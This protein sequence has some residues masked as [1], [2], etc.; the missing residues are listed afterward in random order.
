MSVIR[1]HCLAIFVALSLFA[2]GLNTTALYDMLEAMKSSFG[3]GVVG[4]QWLV[5][6]YMLAVTVSI[7]AGG[8]LCDY[9]S[10][11]TLFIGGCVGFLISCLLVGLSI[12]PFFLF[13]GRVLQGLTV[14]L[15]L[16]ASIALLKT[17]IPEEQQVT[18]F[19]YWS[20]LLGLGFASGPTLGGLITDWMGWRYVFFITALLILLSLLASFFLVPKMNESKKPFKMDGLGLFFFVLGLTLFV[21][22]F[23]QAQVWGWTHT[24]VLV[25]MLFGVFL[26]Y[27]FFMIEKVATVPIWPL[28][29]FANA[30]LMASS[31]GNISYS[32]GVAITLNYLLVFFQNPLLMHLSPLMAGLALL[33]FSIMVFLVSILMKRIRVWIS[34][35]ATML[36]IG[37]IFLLAAFVWFAFAGQSSVYGFFVVPILFAG[38]AVGVLQSNLPSLAASAVEPAEMGAAVGIN[39]TAFYFGTVIAITVCGIIYDHVWHQVFVTQLSSAHFSSTVELNVKHLLHIPHLNTVSAMSF[40]PKDSESIAIYRHAVV[41]AFSAVMLFTVFFNGVIAIMT[42]ML[43]KRKGE[44]C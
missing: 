29:S 14:S 5:N 32:M 10:K 42:L 35:T 33:P 7:L 24:V 23:M 40:L 25:A 18:A 31:I 30:R 16:P 13:L 4:M 38:V 44:S 6:S 21:V 19:G 22:G 1:V 39:W 3:F 43:S 28:Y 36:L 8:K 2:L 9:F 26:L 12:D 34:S 15:T 17:V 27:S 11:K 41:K 37:F 20:A